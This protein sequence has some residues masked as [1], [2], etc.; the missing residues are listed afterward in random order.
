MLK[1][2]MDFR[3]GSGQRVCGP[4]KRKER[5]NDLRPIGWCRFIK[6]AWSC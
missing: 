4:V 5:H 6:E 1:G 3:L 2:K